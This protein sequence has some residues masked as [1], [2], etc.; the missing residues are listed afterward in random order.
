MAPREHA[1]D[2]EPEAFLHIRASD[3]FP[4]ALLRKGAYLLLAASLSAVGVMWRDREAKVAALD[5][6]TAGLS[7]VNVRI[8]N[9]ERRVDAQN[10]IALQGQ[11]E[12]KEDLREYR[13]EVRKMYQR[14]LAAGST[15]RP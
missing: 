15:A 10:A 6:N 3:R 1:R 11:A 7:L 9:L 5:A 13:D 8:D 14:A 2:D 4:Q 12:I